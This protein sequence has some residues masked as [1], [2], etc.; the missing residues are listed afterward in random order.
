MERFN[1]NFLNELFNPRQSGDGK[2][3]GKG[4][5]F[6]LATTGESGQPYVQFRGGANCFLKVLNSK[7]V[8]EKSFKS[9]T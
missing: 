6:Y 8:S 1:G 4:D 5:G 9:P 7:S 3:I 2:P